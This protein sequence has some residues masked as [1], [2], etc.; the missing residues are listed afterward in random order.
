M[1]GEMAQNKTKPKNKQ[2]K[3]DPPKTKQTN[4]QNLNHLPSKQKD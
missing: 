2:T 1:T 4:K 3:K